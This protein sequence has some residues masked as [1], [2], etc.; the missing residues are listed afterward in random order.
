MRKYAWKGLLIFIIVEIVFRF[1]IDPVYFYYI[2]SYTIDKTKF[3]FKQAY[4]PKDKDHIDYLFIG[5]SRTDAAINITEINRRNSTLVAVNAGRGYS[6]GAVHYWALKK[7]IRNNPNILK[8]SNVVIEVA[9][10]VNYTENFEKTKYTLRDDFVHL[11]LPHLDFSL[12]KDFIKFSDCKSGSKLRLVLLYSSSLYRTLPFV[13]NK[14][15]EMIA[16]LDHNSSLK[17]GVGTKAG[18]LSVEEARQLLIKIS[19]N[20]IVHQKQETPLTEKELDYSML[21]RI[22]DLVVRNGGKL[23]L[24]EMPVHSIQR[25]V[26]ETDLSMQNKETFASWAKH[27][28]ISIIYIE[29]FKYSDKDFPDYW[30]LAQNRSTEFTTKLFDKLKML[31]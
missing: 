5:E 13:K 20:D 27:N 12:L 23:F 11:I 29:D 30:H 25:A 6:T 28:Y 19:T 22:N 8:N 10:G 26:F 24:Y 21:S 7:M 18:N 15:H 31:E 14:L 3:T 16:K 2:N 9:G 4:F 1:V 17:G